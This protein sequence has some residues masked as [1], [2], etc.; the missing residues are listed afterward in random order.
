[1]KTALVIGIIWAVVTFILLWFNYRFHERP[2]IKDG[3]RLSSETIER[4][5][6]KE[7]GMGPPSQ[8]QRVRRIA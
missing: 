2:T 4:I 1:M 6:K 8:G 7:E 5:K 3:E